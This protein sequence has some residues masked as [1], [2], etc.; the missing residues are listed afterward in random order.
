MVV[1]GN[2]DDPGLLRSAVE[3]GVNQDGFAALAPRVLHAPN[4]VQWVWGGV[5]FGAL[6]GAPSVDHPARVEGVSW[7]RD[8][9]ISEGEIRT[10]TS[11]G[12]VDVMV[13]HDVPA[14]L[15]LPLPP[16]PA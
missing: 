8:E 13:T 15:R 9:V 6:G 11:G 7:W 1:G 10:R 14:G 4:G 5:R 16:P 12:P 2:H 3:R